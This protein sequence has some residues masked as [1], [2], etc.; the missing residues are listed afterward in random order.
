MTP[1][2]TPTRSA[3]SPAPLLSPGS[4]EL[5]EPVGELLDRFEQ[6]AIDDV[7]ATGATPT[8]VTAR[9]QGRVD[10]RGPLATVLDAPDVLWAGRVATNPVHRIA[11]PADW[12]V[13][14]G[15]E[16]PRATH[17]STGA[18]LQTEGDQVVAECAD[19]RCVDRH[20]IQLAPQHN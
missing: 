5:D 6:A 20:P 7:I 3:S 15:P 10:V 17:S 12:Q 16:E 11:D 4:P 8:P 1:A 14:D 13:H 18:R 19:R 2:T 9:R